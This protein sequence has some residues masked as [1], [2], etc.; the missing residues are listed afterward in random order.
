MIPIEHSK[1][2]TN[3]RYRVDWYKKPNGWT[4]KAIYCVE[5]IVGALGF[6]QVKFRGYDLLHDISNLLFYT[7]E[8]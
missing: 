2:E 8:D 3:K 1:I 5:E 6:T 4:R 7:L